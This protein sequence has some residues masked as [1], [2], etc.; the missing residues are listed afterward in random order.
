MGGLGDPFGGPGFPSK[1]RLPIERASV[2]SERSRLPMGGIGYPLRG[3]TFLKNATPQ[4][5]YVRFE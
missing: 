3:L 2:P 4:E 1:P 5:L